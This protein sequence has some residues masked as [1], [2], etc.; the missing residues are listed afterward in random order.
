MT[1]KNISTTPTIALFLIISV[2]GIFL[3]LHVGSPNVKAIH[4]WLGL[5]FVVCAILHAIANWKLMK[6][7]LGGMKAT[8]IG[9]MLVSAV[10]YSVVAVPADQGGNPIKSLIGRV[11]KAPL[12]TI[13][14]IY[15]QKSDALVEQ[16]RDNGYSI[17]GVDTTL[18]DIAK[19]N[20]IPAEQII[21]LIARGQEK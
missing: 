16:L 4:Q 10:A 11:L 17:A 12:S 20:S 8:A 14:V 7:Y 6:R 18:E 13:A 2:T 5:V 19:Q 1:A 21:A 3:L 15:G 9:L